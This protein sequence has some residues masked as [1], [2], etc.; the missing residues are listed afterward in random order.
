MGILG[1]I[2][3]ITGI[4]L[5][6]I[7]RDQKQRAFSIKSA[8]PMTATELVEMAGAVAAEIGGG[9]WRDYIKLWGE[10]ETEGPLYSEHKQEACVHYVSEVTREYE[11]T[12]T[13]RDSNG[14]TTTER[15][16]TSETIS[17]HQQ[18]KP[19][20]LRDRT[21]TI[22]I[23]PEGANIETITILDEFRPQRSGDTL[24]YRYK[25]S[26]LPVGREVLVV[27]AVSDLTGDVVVG[28]PVQSQHKYI[29]SLK[30][31]EMLASAA[32]QSAKTLSYLMI[33]FFVLGLGL[34]LWDLLF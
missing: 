17:R 25:E 19:F 30:N 27:G 33:A 29:I 31:E 22:K 9:S 14:T 21:G 32:E 34:I 7:R 24:G 13:T 8:R 10:I 16:R 28:K 4:I 2:L 12:T 6:F 26:I 11:A 18:S 23:D 20:F 3:L 1:I 15:K 5:F